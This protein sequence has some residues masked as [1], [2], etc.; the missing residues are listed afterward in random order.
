MD[1]SKEAVFFDVPHGGNFNIYF[2]HFKH[3]HIM[4]FE[5]FED[6]LNVQPVLQQFNYYIWQC[7][8]IVSMSWDKGSYQK[9]QCK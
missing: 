1:K 4:A 9:D 6:K 5:L 8:Y 2:L 7:E 3:R